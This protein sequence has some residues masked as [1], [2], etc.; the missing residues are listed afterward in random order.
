MKKRHTLWS[1]QPW[2]HEKQNRCPHGKI[3]LVE[4]KSVK[5][6]THDNSFEVGKPATLSTK[7][8]SVNFSALEHKSTDVCATGMGSSIDKVE[9]LRVDVWLESLLCSMSSEPPL[10][11][12]FWLHNAASS[13]L[14]SWTLLRL[15]APEWLEVDAAS[16]CSLSVLQSWSSGLKSKIK[17]SNTT[18]SISSLRSL[19]PLR[20][21]PATVL[22]SLPLR[23]F[24]LSFLDSLDEHELD[25]C[26]KNRKW[27]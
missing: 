3:P 1:T 17:G 2:M 16:V 12:L 26:L 11:V 6:I 14:F 23:I 10:I 27:R 4:L 19:L 22:P 24:L 18:T 21:R 20:E 9:F 7:S 5:H 15:T 13:L 8:P 25:S